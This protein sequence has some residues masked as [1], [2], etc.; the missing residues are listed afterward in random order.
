MEL[1]DQL[2]NENFVS[3]IGLEKQKKLDDKKQKEDERLQ[4]KNE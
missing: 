3:K 4:K 1:L 2:N